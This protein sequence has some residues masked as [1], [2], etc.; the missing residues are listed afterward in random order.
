ML[1]IGRS[2]ESTVTDKSVGSICKLTQLEALDLRDTYLSKWG[3]NQL[4]CLTN[5][6]S[7]EIGVSDLPA[8][9]AAL[10][11]SR[12]TKLRRLVLGSLQDWDLACLSGLHDLEWLDLSGEISEA[13]LRYLA[14]MPR[15]RLLQ[16]Y[17][18]T[19]SSG[20]G[21]IHLASLKRLDSLRLSGRIPDAAVAHLACLSPSVG[22]L[23]I[24]TLEPIQDQT[25]AG[26][27]Q[28]LPRLTEI[29][30]AKPLPLPASRDASPRGQGQK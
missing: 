30:V 28:A 16:I 9:P 1:W 15:L 4:G 17:G 12:L 3:L 5:L 2:K 18:V 29:R 8:D 7:L 25:L 23:I 10:D 14:E 22:G 6:R 26:V 13:S 19:C 21:L 20:E 24:E 27:K 11:L